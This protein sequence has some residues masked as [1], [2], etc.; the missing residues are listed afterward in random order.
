MPGPA[1]RIP[2]ERYDTVTREER[3]TAV[4]G[5][6]EA[7]IA[8]VVAYILDHP[9]APLL[10]QD[11]ADLAAM[12]LRTF[13]HVFASVTGASLA[14]FVRTARVAHAR[15]LLRETDLTIAEVMRCSGFSST[16]LGRRAFLSIT[17]VS[18]VQYR[19]ELRARP[20]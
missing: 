18:P 14:T 16:E 12:N 17:Q 13:S 11:L 10:R 2:V 7:A 8:R 5:A 4:E 3:R 9:Q 20:D 19:S 15:Y 6:R 1:G